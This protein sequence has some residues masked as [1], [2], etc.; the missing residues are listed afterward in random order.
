M[1]KDRSYFVI[2]D[3]LAICPTL[4]HNACTSSGSNQSCYSNTQMCDF[5]ND[6]PGGEDESNCLNNKR[7]DFETGTCDWLASKNTFFE[8]ERHRAWTRNGKLSFMIS[9]NCL[10]MG[11]CLREI[12]QVSLISLRCSVMTL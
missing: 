3:Y 9:L 2:P 12:F 11:W 6:C 1:T 10:S 7:C 8:W 4:T 5:R